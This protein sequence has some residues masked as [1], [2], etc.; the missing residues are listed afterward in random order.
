M[1]CLWRLF[2]HWQPHGHF[3]EQDPSVFYVHFHP[4]DGLPDYHLYGAGF[5]AQYAEVYV[6]SEKK[7]V[8][9]F[10]NDELRYLIVGINKKPLS[11][12]RSGFF[13]SYNLFSNHHS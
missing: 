9:L 1:E 6:G 3:D 11:L 7:S 8:V 2:G 5:L 4:Y 12:K 10:V 13:N